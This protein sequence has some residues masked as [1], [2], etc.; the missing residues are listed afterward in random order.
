M[1]PSL[2][3]PALFSLF[4]TLQ[5]GNALVL[6]DDVG[7]LP[8]LGWN[9]WNAFHCDVDEDKIMTAANQIVSLGLKD[10]GYEYVNSECFFLWFWDL[11]CGVRIGRRIGVIADD[12]ESG[13]P[14]AEEVGEENMVW[15]NEFVRAI[16]DCWSVQS[17][18]DNVT[19]QI[20]PDPVKFPDGI[21]GT[22]D[23]IHA[24]GLKIGIYSSAGL[25]TC[26]KYPA[27]FGYES[28]DAAT[29]A[30]WGIDYL[31]YDNCGIPSNWTDE[32]V[33]CVPESTSLINGTCP[34]TSSSPPPGYDWSTSN[35]AER[36][37][38]MRDALL[39]QNRTILYSLCE[40]GTADVW[41]WGNET[42]SSWRMSGDISPSWARTAQILNENSFDLNSV[43]FWGH[44]DADMLEVGNGEL[45][46]EE[47]R[48]HF[49][50]WAAMKSPVI[51]GTSLD[52]LAPE[53]VDI[54]KNKYLLAFSQDSTY[55]G[56]ATPYK[57]GTN[58][59]WTFNATNPA[60]YWS[61][62]SEAGTLVLALNSL[63]ETAERQIVWSELPEYKKGWCENFEVTDIWTGEN[64]GYVPGGINRTLNAHDTMG[65]IV[66]QKWGSSGSGKRW[67]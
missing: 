32:Y 66:T 29:F 1:Y 21:S 55:G 8:A 56:P 48:S 16:D 17:G 5:T 39:A 23:K 60:E 20:I 36:Y 46:V 58:P 65:F 30:S 49:A 2:T 7:K 43:G 38:R 51:I 14:T 57:W 28:I 12:A 47:N 19:Q 63:N 9:S 67:N 62:Q 42:G 33:A 37:R 27:S 59:D 45:T 24:L 53:L 26:A 10:A 34:T 31:K 44:N 25:K 6:K 18:R 22:A 35:S 52:T 4:A 41:A 15:R 61:G 64:L 50:F 54:L 13:D 11:E 40:W 3:L